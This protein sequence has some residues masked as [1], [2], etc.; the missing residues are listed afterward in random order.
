MFFFFFF[1][2]S[3]DLIPALLHR[4]CLFLV[5]GFEPPVVCYLWALML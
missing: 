3:I 1:G 2:L 5:R 4:G